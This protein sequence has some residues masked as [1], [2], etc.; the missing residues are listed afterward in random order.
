MRRARRPRPHRRR[1]AAARVRRVP[2]RAP[3]AGASRADAAHRRGLTT[4]QIARALLMTV[5]TVQQRIVRA[6]RTLADAGVPFEVPDRAERPARLASVLQVDLSALHRGLCRR[7]R[8][9]AG[10]AGC[11]A[12]GGATRAAAV[13]ADAV[14]AR[15]ARAHR[16]HGVPV[17]ALR[18][19]RRPRWSAVDAR[20]AG[21][22]ALGSLRD[23][24]RPRRAGSERMPPAGVSGTTACRP[25]SPSATRSR[26]PFDDTDWAPDRRALRR[27]R[28]ARALARGRVS[29][30]PSR[31]RWPATRRRR[32]R[33][34]TVS[35]TTSPT[36]ARCTPCGPS[37]WSGS[38]ERM[39]RPRSSCAAAALP[40]NDAEATVLQR[41]AAA[42]V[43][44][45]SARRLRSSIR[46]SRRGSGSDPGCSRNLC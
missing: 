28:D 36:S 5:P 18:R 22:T 33:S 2:P 4:E 10:P 19:P 26:R 3:R 29:T 42:L 14:G 8:T 11:R 7:R 23:R 1:R 30:A 25:P 43:A 27:P 45:A 37:C 32:S 34:S 46:P 21:S 35:A 12:R 24:P 31:C 15:G 13:G 38:G 44:C 40:G 6:K 41:R 39:P 20:R 17:V 16:A 9:I